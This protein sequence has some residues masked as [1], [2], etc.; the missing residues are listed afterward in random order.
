MTK[1]P[2][3][4][5]NISVKERLLALAKSNNIDFNRVLLLYIQERF[6]YRMSLSSYKLNFILKGGILFYAGYKESARS[7][8]D[9][10]LLVKKIPNHTGDVKSVFKHI[11]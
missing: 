11:L 6:L 3:K 1:K 9:I 10:D 4:N 8:R 7:T 2:I 5:I